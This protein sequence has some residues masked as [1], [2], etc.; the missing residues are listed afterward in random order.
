MSILSYSEIKEKKIIIWNEEPFEVLESHVARTQQRKP[1]NQVKMRSLINGRA[2]NETFRS[3]DTASEADLEKREVKFLYTNKGEFWFADPSDPSNRFKL[4]EKILGSNVKFLKPNENVTA[5]VW[6]DEDD[7][8]KIISIN[9]P[10]KMTYVVKEA[11]PA[12]KGDTRTGGNKVVTLENGA[13]INAPLFIAEGD[14]IIVNTETGEYV[15]RA[16]DK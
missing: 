5:L 14:K 13:T 11:P 3:S 10:I 6:T 1:Q 15:E 7:E 4:D 16:S 9:L 12:I 8:E 2:V